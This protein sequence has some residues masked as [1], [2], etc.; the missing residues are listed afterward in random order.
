MK[1][2]I[3]KVVAAAVVLG[4]TALAAGCNNMC[5]PDPVD[6]PL[7]MN[8]CKGSNACKGASNRNSCKGHK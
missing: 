1:K 8:H 2:E 3:L 7:V 6:K 5:G 4:T